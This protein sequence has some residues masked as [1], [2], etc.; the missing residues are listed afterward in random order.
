MYKKPHRVGHG[1]R[2]N[3]HI[4]SL[5]LLSIS[6]MRDERPH[7]RKI[8]RSNSKPSIQTFCNFSTVGEWVGDS[9]LKAKAKVSDPK[10][11]LK[12]K[13]LYFYAMERSVSVFCYQIIRT[14]LRQKVYFSSFSL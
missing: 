6:S 5:N 8:R 11:N 12:A 13:V 10:D 9:M 14:M 7:D 3:A 2:N 4:S 1:A